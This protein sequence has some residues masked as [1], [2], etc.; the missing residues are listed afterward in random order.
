MRHGEC[1]VFAENNLD[2]TGVIERLVSTPY[3]V[4]KS[5]VASWNGRK[6]EHKKRFRFKKDPAKFLE[7]IEDRWLNQ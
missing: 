4:Y 2:E 7:K 6:E 1:I 5:E 3:E